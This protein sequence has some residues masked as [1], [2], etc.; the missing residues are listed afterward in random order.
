MAK[1]KAEET[2]KPIPEDLINFWAAH[3]EWAEF[4]MDVLINSK[5]LSEDDEMVISEREFISSMKKQLL[6]QG[7][8]VIKLTQIEFQNGKVYFPEQEA[9]YNS[10]KNDARERP[11]TRDR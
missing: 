9:S 11:T 5:C 3:V 4:W 2:I 7:R 10:R 6:N 8:S 1:Q